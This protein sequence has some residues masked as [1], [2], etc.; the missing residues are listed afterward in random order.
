[1]EIVIDNSSLKRSISG[2]ITGTIYLQIDNI[3]FPA[4]KWNDFVV[5]LLN[6]WIEALQSVE[7]K[8][9]KNKSLPFR[10]MDGPYSFV[11]HSS[12]DNHSTVVLYE[13]NTIL[14][15]YIINIKTFSE[16]LKKASTEILNSLNELKWNNRDVELLKHN[17]SKVE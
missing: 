17:I 4:Y 12:I 6:W 3:Q 11:L 5:V 15:E 2:S 16:S 10:F 8:S 14:R 9:E 1:M 7:Y 13:D